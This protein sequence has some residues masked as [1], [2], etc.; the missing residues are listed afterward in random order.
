MGIDGPG[1]LVRAYGEDVFSGHIFVFVS[2][3]RDRLK[4][5]AWDTGGFVV[6]YKRLEKDVFN[7]Q[8]PSPGKRRCA[9]IRPSSTCCSTASSFAI[10]NGPACGSHPIG[11]GREF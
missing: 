10:S 6:Y 4:A 8:G 5:L 11:R 3:R 2:R 7:F 1:A 9:L